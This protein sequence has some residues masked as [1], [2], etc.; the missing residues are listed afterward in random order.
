MIGAS[1]SASTGARLIWAL[2]VASMVGGGALR[3]QDGEDEPD[4]EKEG[5]QP[6]APP[7]LNPLPLPDS[8]RLKVPA[9][10]PE[11]ARKAI[12]EAIDAYKGVEQA[13]SGQEKLLTRAIARLKAASGKALKCALPHFYLGLAYQ[14]RKNFAQA[15]LSLEKAVRLDP[16]LAEAYIELADVHVSLKKLPESLPLYDKALT[17]DKKS[18]VAH[19]RK[20]LSLI[21]QGK[22]KEAKTH[23][24]SA[25]KSRTTAYREYV[26]QGIDREIQG[27]G[28]TKSH[29]HET[30]NYKVI[31]PVSEDFAREIGQHAEM[32][33]KVYDTLFADIKKPDRK[34]EIW[35]FPSM[36][37]YHRGGGPSMAAG[38]YDPLFRKLVLPKNTKK[39]E[40]FST[41]YHEA[42]HQYLHDYL[43]LA[44]QWFNEGL[45]DYF[46]AYKLEMQGG[47]PVMRSGADKDRLLYAQSGIRRKILPPAM[48]LMLMTRAEMYEPR[49]VGYHYAM[50]WGMMY[51]MIEGPSPQYKKVLVSYFGALRKGSDQ[52]E[53]FQKTFGRL[54]MR[55]FDQEWQGFIANRGY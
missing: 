7:I 48:D 28:W 18:D 49:M 33:R 43:E 54:D 32:I 27:P 35:V 36:D 17:I 55:R 9:D 2:A 34:Y 41:L 8:E 3:A 13:S 4:K 10:L 51:F 37:A 22:L 47:R 25:K 16:G 46:G 26:L 45:G 6:K 40:T 12:E 20:A 19:E 44:P 30:E 21:R 52:E 53:A 5:G 1:R 24:S 38:H 39:E 15:K 14:Q 23:L 50:A 31:T 42:F 29:T 11:A